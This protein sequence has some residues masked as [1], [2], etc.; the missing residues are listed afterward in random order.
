[1][2]EVTWPWKSL[3]SHSW[4]RS[5][6]FVQTPP[7]SYFLDQGLD[8]GIQCHDVRGSIDP[9]DLWWKVGR[10]DM[11]LIACDSRD[12]YRQWKL[13]V[14]S[15]R[16]F[17]CAG[18]WSP[19]IHFVHFLILNKEKNIA[20]WSLWGAWLCFASALT[21]SHVLGYKLSFPSDIR[22]ASYVFMH[23]TSDC[24]HQHMGADWHWFSGFSSMIPWHRWQYLKQFECCFS[25]G[26][27]NDVLV[28]GLEFLSSAQRTRCKL[29]RLQSLNLWL[30][31]KV[32][33][34]AY[35]FVSAL[36]MKFP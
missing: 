14:H 29:K 10:H 36:E 35:H 15:S 6:V 5:R 11:T 27:W 31:A 22:Y 19:V 3:A 25:F 34:M 17:S 13:A 12:H 4:A 1:M 28:R 30:S 20:C 23:R 21:R 33:R 16:D 26:H 32:M 8:S 7:P 24:W 2:L 18:T 9:K